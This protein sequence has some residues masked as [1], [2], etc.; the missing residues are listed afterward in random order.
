[1]APPAAPVES[2]NLINVNGNG[3]SVSGLF[4]N[5]AMEHVPIKSEPLDEEENNDVE[6][7][8]LPTG[9]NNRQRFNLGKCHVSLL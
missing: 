8:T 3:T 7:T 5:G 9:G 1:M 4:N 6:M 2:S